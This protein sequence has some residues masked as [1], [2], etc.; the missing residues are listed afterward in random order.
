MRYRTFLG[1]GFSCLIA[2][3]ALAQE[4][5]PTTREARAI[6]RRA[7][8]QLDQARESYEMAAKRL[9]ATE[10]DLRDAI[11]RLDVSPETLRKAA[12]R[13]DEQL[14][15]L[16][17]DEVGSAARRKATEDAIKQETV[18]AD[19]RIQTDPVVAALQK[20]VVARQ[21]QFKQLTSMHQAGVA[22]KADVDAADAAVADAQAKV[23]ER[24]HAVFTGGDSETLAALRHDMLNLTISEQERAARIDFL[25]NQKAQLSH[26]LTNLPELQRLQEA[27]ESSRRL[28]DQAEERVQTLRIYGETDGGGAKR[29]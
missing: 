4:A 3:P 23:A 18:R 5:Q 8:L 29:E 22:S 21:E 6:A 9:D 26:G 11:G 10:R 27:I 28:L 20:V 12:A 19:A 13:L 24:Q 16:Q 15:M 1:I 17:L 7:E 2:L 25:K 14:E